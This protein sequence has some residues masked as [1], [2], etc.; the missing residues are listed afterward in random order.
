MFN[1]FKQGRVKIGS[2][3]IA[4][5]C[6]VESL[7]V[8]RSLSQ[9]N[10]TPTSASIAAQML[11]FPLY[12]ESNEG[13]TDASVKYLTRGKG[14]TLYFTPQEI[15]MVLQKKLEDSEHFSSSILKMQFVGAKTN[16]LVQG[17]EEQASK[18]H[19]YIGNDPTNWHTNI[20]NYAKISYQDLYPGIDAVFYG[21]AQQLEYDILVAPHQNP[22]QAVL[23]IE[24]TKELSIDQSGNLHMLIADD[25]DICMQKPFVYQMVDGEKITIQG[26]FVLLAQNDVG[27][28]IGTYDKSK[29]LV[30]D[31]TVSYSTYLGGPNSY[32]GV[33]TGG[34]T[35][36]STGS[37]Y[38][39]GSTASTSFPT[40]SSNPNLPPFQP[41]YG[42]GFTDAYVTKLNS[43]GTELVYSTYLGGSGADSGNDIAID[44]AGNAYITGTTN[45][46]D[47][48]TSTGSFQSTFQPTIQGGTAAF[49]TKLNADGAALAYSTYLAG[50]T[51]AF[52]ASVINSGN[53]IAVNSAGNA[54]I[55]GST[56]ASDFPS[57]SPYQP[58]YGGGLS[59]AFIAQLN[60]TGTALVYSTYLGGSS[61]DYGN[62]IAIDSTG[63]AYIVGTTSSTD[64][65]TTAGVYQG[66]FAGASPFTSSNAFITKL[67]PSGSALVYSTY[68]GGVG[69]DVGNGIALDS[70]G[71]AYIIGTTS[72][73]NFPTL[74]AVQGTYGGD[75]DAFVTKL[76]STGS[77]LIYST[78][79]GGDSIDRGLAIATDGKNQVYATGITFSTNFPTK[80]VIQQKTAGSGL[81]NAFITK[82]DIS[83]SLIYSTYFGGS[84]NDTGTG[85]AVNGIEDVYV[86]GLTM[87][88]NFPTT[89]GAFQTTLSGLMFASFVVKIVDAPKVTNISPR[90]RPEAGGDAVIITGENFTGAQA[91]TFGGAPA[92]FTVNS[93]T[94]I[95]AITPPGKGMVHVRVTTFKGISSESSADQFLYVPITPPAPVVSPPQDVRGRQIK[96]QFAT[97]T[98]FVN[99]IT[100]Q[101]PSSGTTPTVYKI[102]RN[103][104]LSELI[105]VVSANRDRLEF[106]DHNRREGRTYTYFIISV[107][108]AGNQSTAAQVIVEPR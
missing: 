71:N 45:S 78:Y 81:G 6:L 101:A 90:A 47:F 39:T 12:F 57:V 43:T 65:P 106:I 19:Y 18:S 41:N 91:V 99:V 7:C 35:V 51:S 25:Q 97:Q 67:A 105:D 70:S 96:N 79:L 75:S 23:H 59:D 58:A 32:A 55:A 77:A 95:T 63:N 60:S 34:I 84:G 13:Q 66:A 1:L 82:L 102:F 73:T 8:Y 9:L 93:D 44:S 69:P 62:D 94:Q 48:P 89:P 15:V 74:N 56:T 72:S 40:A 16:P 42:G 76:N 53:G 3:F 85:I 30:I 107:D 108:A 92:M 17:L 29:V 14:Y 54:Y 4:L 46:T 10:A 33:G 27:F 80:N 104:A 88:Q 2:A 50:P 22:Q 37:A 49:V 28:V 20:S 98:E 38:V 103:A 64:F 83:G 36:D 61:A 52:G 24:G 26:Q 31:P 21:N 86:T 87:S 11:Q 5:L 68:L 100:W